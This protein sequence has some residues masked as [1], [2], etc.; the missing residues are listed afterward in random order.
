MKQETKNLGCIVQ[1]DKV[2]Y[3]V[4]VKKEIVIKKA[5]MNKNH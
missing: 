2:I 1:T 5:I 3:K 4:I